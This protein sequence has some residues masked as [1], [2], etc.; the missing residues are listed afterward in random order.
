MSGSVF[1]VDCSVLH[2]FSKTS[3]VKLETEKRRSKILSTE[4]ESAPGIYYFSVTLAANVLS[5]ES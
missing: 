4:A 5:R 1:G 2:L 3:S